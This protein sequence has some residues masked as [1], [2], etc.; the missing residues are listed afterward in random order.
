MSA[1]RGGHTSLLADVL[2]AIPWLAPR[3]RQAGAPDEGAANGQRE[4]AGGACTGATSQLTLAVRLQPPEAVDAPAG[5]TAAMRQSHE[6]FNSRPRQ[7]ANDRGGKALSKV[8]SNVKVK[9]P[10][11][12][13][14]FS[15]P[16][17]RPSC[18]TVVGCPVGSKPQGVRPL[19]LMIPAARSDGS[20][21]LEDPVD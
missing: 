1:N 15:D 8:G 14:A 7:R 4:L 13:S 2:S 21:F 5:R 19:P 16:D 6:A 12:V 10:G 9:P 11:S 18:R 3:R 17:R 20:T